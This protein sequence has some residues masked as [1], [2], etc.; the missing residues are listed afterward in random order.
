MP[1]EENETDG[2]VKIL[3]LDFLVC[4]V[5]LVFGIAAAM[6]VAAALLTFLLHL[7]FG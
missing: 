6:L 2:G 3:L 1:N 7:L 4:G 5:M